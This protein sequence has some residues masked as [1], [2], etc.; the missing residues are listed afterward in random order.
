MADQLL[1]AYSVV[2]TRRAPAPIS[3]YARS[4][5]KIHAETAVLPITVEDLG[6][7]PPPNQPTVAIQGSSP[8]ILGSLTTEAVVGQHFG[9]HIIGGFFNSSKPLT[10]SATGLPAG[11]VLNAQTG[12]IS[13][14]PAAG[15]ET[16]SPII[17]HLRV[18]DGV[19]TAAATLTL[20]IGDGMP[21][22]TV[23]GSDQPATG[24]AD[25]VLSFVTRYAGKRAAREVTVQSAST[26]QGP[27]TN[28]NTGVGGY[29][30]E[31]G[32]D[33]YLLNSTNYPPQNGVYFRSRIKADGFPDSISNV[34]GP[35]NLA[36]SK[37]RLG[38][39]LFRVIRNGLRA[40]LDFVA[41]QID[42]TEGVALRVQSSFTPGDEASWTDLTDSGGNNIS[43]MTKGA[44]PPPG[45]LSLGTG[46]SLATNKVKPA[47]GVYFRAVA[48][49]SGSVD[50]VSNVIGPYRMD[51]DTPPTVKIV[52]PAGGS[53]PGSPATL[54]QASDGT[55]VLSINVQATASRPIRTLSIAFDGNIINTF[56]NVSSGQLYT[57]NYQTNLLGDHVIEAIAVD[58]L[59]VTGRAGT[60]PQYIRITP[61]TAGAATQSQ[62]GSRAE[63]KAA[64]L[65]REMYTVANSGGFWFNSSTWRDS[66][67]NPGVPTSADFV[68]IG[69]STVK[70]G[71]SDH[72]VGSAFVLSMNGGH[73]VGGGSLV[74][75]ELLTIA[76]GSFDSFV[77]VIIKQ[78]AVCQLNN[79]GD[80]KLDGI[81]DNQGTLNVHGAGGLSGIS[82]FNNLGK[83]TF[84]PVLLPTEEVARGLPLD[85][86][87][88]SA[89]DFNISGQVG[90]S[91]SGPAG[92]ISSGGSALI[93]NDGA[94]L[95]SNDGGSLISNDGGSLV[96]SG[97]GGLISDDGAELI[98]NDGASLVT[99]NGS[100]IV[101]S[102]GG[103][104][105]V[106]AATGARSP[107]MRA[108]STSSAFNISSGEV[109]LTNVFISGPVTLNGGVL[110]GTGQI[111]GSLTNN[112]GYIKPGHSPGTITV[113]GNFSQASGGTM[114]LEAA[115]GEARLFDRLQIAGS[116][117][118]GGKLDLRTINGYVPLPND[119]FNP[120]GYK[121]V[122]GSFATVSANAK[123][124]VNPT[125]LLSV[126]DPAKPNPQGGRLLN[127]STR[128][129]TETG[130]NVLIGGFYITGSAPKKVLIRA[131]GPS[132]PVS[133]AL[134]DPVLE[135][136]K[137]DGTVVTNDNWKSNQQAE[138][139]ATTIPPSSDLESAIVVT[140][141]P[142]GHTAIVRG[143]DDGTG[144]ALVEVYD[145][146][147]TAPEQLA[148]ISTRGQ[149]QT[150]DNV[151]IGGFIVGGGEPA[152]VLIR[153]IGPSLPVSGKLQDTIL[154]LHDSNG[155]TLIN[156][157]WR[158]TQE[159]EI[160]ATTIPPTDNRE[161]AMIATLPGGNYT[162]V[163]R[164][165]NDATGVGLVE[166]YNLQ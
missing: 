89:S 34:V 100:G 84:Q 88:I 25:T 154:E 50:S 11:F 16:T 108:A 78:G 18:T 109:D 122:N 116:A 45:A 118:L 52:S 57:L 129:R 63:V 43:G 61:S 113:T 140:L 31:F 67:G 35:F 95:I 2:N 99:D 24:L 119:A 124:T 137:A 103:G 151:M 76:G 54:K 41:T 160:I 156:D 70:L 144:V 128:M 17:I 29:M 121:S 9:Y 93:G 65:R 133:G 85:P 147:A 139:K 105:K 55:L 96:S 27:W 142:G 51:S 98:G 28:L 37:P 77:H 146:G 39:T 8:R 152:K 44:T 22:F 117:K 86:R 40:D 159:S 49:A 130:E 72:N 38:Q 30:T 110:S 106:A 15:T 97:N 12:V 75:G 92:L 4:N 6:A 148:N 26:P 125:G 153:A 66:R 80:V 102:F 162:A 90:Q 115:G 123:V 7:L 145:L 58:D 107:G 48:A 158:A 132:L 5:A 46:Y 79:A 14:I 13:G 23:N 56:K 81:L 134:A 126:I 143:K 19:D 69:G 94:S 135:L 87:A 112:G 83:V 91:F 21:V 73:I 33:T 155:S 1:S 127:I 42:R 47:A 138:I 36:S 149:V 161:S 114:I 101:S 74:I 60:G 53:D 82:I 164:G 141:P 71:P 10:Y 150:G 131:I 20:T 59:G 120:L 64:T 165:K 68:V 62:N 136:H 3:D 104:F 32:T 157:D 111:F 166:A 163:V